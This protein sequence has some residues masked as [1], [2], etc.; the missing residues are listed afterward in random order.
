MR[1]KDKASPALLSKRLRRSQ[2]ARAAFLHEYPDNFE[3]Q[4][5]ISDVLST[6]QRILNMSAYEGTRGCLARPRVS[7]CSHWRLYKPL[8]VGPSSSQ[9]LASR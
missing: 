6:F 2:G 4:V 7:T 5:V 8:E 9:L 3:L 1:K